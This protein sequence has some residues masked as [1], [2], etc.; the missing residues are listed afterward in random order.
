MSGAIRQSE[1][2]AGNDWMVLYKAFSQV[3]LNAYD[4]DTIRAAMVSYIQQNYP[5]DFNDWINSSEFVAILDLLAYTGQS[6]AFRMDINA[7]E[8]FIDI[9]RR[10]ESVLRLARFLSYNSHR[11]LPASGLVKIVSIQ[12]TD[13]VYDSNGKNLSNINVNWG[14][15]SNSNW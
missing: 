11:N 7:R 5:E 8:N 14:D 12:T 15:I 1:L 9:A 6:L 3:N 4:F 10:R 2:F 13:D